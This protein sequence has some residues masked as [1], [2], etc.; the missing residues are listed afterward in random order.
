M[1]ELGISDDGK[2]FFRNSVDNTEKPRRD[3]KGKSLLKFVKSYVVLDLETTGLDPRYDEIIELAAIKV[4]DN[5]IVDDFSTLVK[6]TASIGDFITELTGIDN[7]MVKDSP[8]VKEV[9]PDFLKFIESNIVVAHNANFDINFLYDNCIHYLNIPFVN[10][11]IDT[12]R[13]SRRIFKD[14]QSHKLSNFVKEFNL[15]CDVEHRA[16][17]DCRLVLKFYQLLQSH[18][19]KNNIDFDELIKQSELRAKNIKAT[20]SELDENHALF[21]KLCVFTGTL[22]KVRRHE[23]MQIVVNLGGKCADNVT[24]KTDYLILGNHDYAKIKDEKSNKQRKAESLQLQGCKIEVL[25]ENV[26]Y[27]LLEFDV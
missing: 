20:V 15:G 12:M 18:V 13:I 23:A 1:Y 26:F 8:T 24:K 25:S 5:K 7:A 3:S 27:D 17:L 21:N 2:I 11:F 22:E 6:P 19:E 16:L 4:V 14:F 10:D 9:L